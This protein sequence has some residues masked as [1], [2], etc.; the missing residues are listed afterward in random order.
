MRDPNDSIWGLWDPDDK[1]PQIWQLSR[2]LL[3]LYGYSLD[4]V[5]D[6]PDFPVEDRYKQVYYWNHTGSVQ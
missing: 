3:E 5:Y 1:S 6:E 2:S 4:I